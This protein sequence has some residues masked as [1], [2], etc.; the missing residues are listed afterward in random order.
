MRASPVS[1]RKDFEGEARGT[2]VVEECAIDGA[3]RLNVWAARGEEARCRGS[4]EEE[5][6]REDIVGW[7]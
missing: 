7:E 3:L 4:G 1:M 2:G 5:P 6:E